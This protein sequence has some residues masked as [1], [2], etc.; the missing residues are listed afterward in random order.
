MNSRYDPPKV[1]RV[2]GLGFGVYGDHIIIYPKPY[3]MYLR[4]P[5]IFRV[6]FAL[7]QH[8]PFFHVHPSMSFHAV[9]I[10]VRGFGT[11]PRQESPSAELYANLAICPVLNCD[12][13][14]SSN[15]I[16]NRNNS[17][18][19]N[20]SNTSNTSNR[21]NNSIT[22][23]QLGLSEQHGFSCTKPH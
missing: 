14:N 21:K 4:G 20:I 16:S 23:C 11:T 12:K 22:T 13:S 5:I 15:H 17:D 8:T 9:K 19:S 1:H 2:S 3:S 7:L 10:L 6:P 18:T